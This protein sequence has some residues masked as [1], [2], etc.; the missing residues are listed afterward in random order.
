MKRTISLALILAL[1]SIAFAQLQEPC[2]NPQ[3]TSVFAPQ[4]G[5]K[6]S[7][8]LSSRSSQVAPM[9]AYGN[10]SFGDR[11]FAGP[12]LTMQY[13]PRRYAPMGF[14]FVGGFIMSF[15]SSSVIDEDQYIP[16]G[17]SFTRFRSP[18]GR[19]GFRGLYLQSTFG[20]FGA[21]FTYYLAE[22]PFRPYVGVGAFLVGAGYAGDFYSTVTPDAK[23]GVQVEIKNSIS[24]FAE[25]RQLF[26]VPNFIGPGGTRF[27]GSTIAA[28][29][30]SFAP[31]LR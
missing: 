17:A 7:S 20:Y 14:D 15:G 25:V 21:D 1:S 13:S 22:G 9:A 30:I 12:A 6:L 8:R 29:G 3:S 28:V 2:L 24:G 4:N 11:T 18:I 5:S 19:N 23:A 31:S 10:F 26:G 16:A 27:N